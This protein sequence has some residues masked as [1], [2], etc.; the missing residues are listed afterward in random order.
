M[1]ILWHNLYLP[2]DNTPE[3]V[4]T[5]QNALLTHGYTL[6]NPFGAIPGKAYKDSIRLFIAPPSSTQWT[7]I[8][9]TN[10]LTPEARLSPALSQIAP[11]L[12]VAVLSSETTDLSVY[13][14]GEQGDTMG[15]LTPYL[16]EGHTTDDIERVLTASL[17][18][19]QSAKSDDFPMDLLPDD[20]QQQ[21]QHLNPKHIN[22]MFGKLMGQ[23]NKQLGKGDAE[24]ARALLQ[25]NMD[26][27]SPAGRRIRALMRLL[28]IPEDWHKPDFVTLRDAYQIHQRRASKPDAI[29]YPGDNEAMNAV[30]NA[31]NYTPIY[32]G[33][34]E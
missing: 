16:R 1:T 23:V 30:P 2:T 18:N 33:K 31:L 13:E 7:R 27:N 6:Y 32:G 11:C 5:L 9:A 24:S 26:W 10:T 3:I 17:I 25:S 28:T 19:T 22:R 8:L 29:L 20:L 21:A 15:G 34:D 12:S 4:N 14:R